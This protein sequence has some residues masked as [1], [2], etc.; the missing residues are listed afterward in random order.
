[1]LT[2]YIDA[3][4]D[5]RYISCNSM[6]SLAREL[7]KDGQPD[8]KGRNEALMKFSLL[9]YNFA[10]VQYHNPPAYVLCEVGKGVLL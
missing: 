7:W 1:M 3:N 9:E 6:K 10:D 4:L 2:A 8:N 5:S